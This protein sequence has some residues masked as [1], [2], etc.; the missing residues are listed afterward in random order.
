MAYCIKLILGQ[1]RLV[2]FTCFPFYDEKD[3]T[4]FLKWTR[5]LFS[6]RTNTIT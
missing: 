4:L 3:L 6:G 5:D 1:P 2:S